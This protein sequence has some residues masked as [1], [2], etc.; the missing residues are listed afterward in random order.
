MKKV[1]LIIMAIGLLTVAV[2][3]CAGQGV[4][5]PIQPSGAGDDVQPHPM[6]EADPIEDG[7]DLGDNS[8]PTPEPNVGS[9]YGDAE[10]PEFMNVSGTVV[11]IETVNDLRHVEIE[12]ADGNTAILVLSDE[13]VFPF[14][15]NIA[16]G[17]TVTGW[18]CANSPMILIY[19][20]QYTILVLSS[21]MG[22]DRNIAVDRF[23][24]S[25][26][27]SDKYFVSQDGMLMF[28]V[29]DNT[30]IIL[31]DGQDFK[32]GDLDNRRIVVIYGPS[33]RSIPA[34]TTAEKLIVL[35]EGIVPVFGGA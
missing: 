26:M 22:D 23:H 30:E 14:S 8:E 7:Q 34:Q 19:P 1:L 27:S 9:D 21:R 13:T 32:D 2:V 24:I 20:P 3:G 10:I 31:A 28:N 25:D 17:D 18:Y 11:N 16:I 12:D 4:D 5:L 29:D 33:T 35:F 6:P 15:E